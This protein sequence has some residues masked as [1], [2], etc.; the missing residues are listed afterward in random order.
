M[1]QELLV[2]SECLQDVGL[3]KREADFFVVLVIAYNKIFHLPAPSATKN[4]SDEIEFFYDYLIPPEKGIPL[5]SPGAF[6]YC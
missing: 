3:T 5:L 2:G 1:L 4:T 6:P